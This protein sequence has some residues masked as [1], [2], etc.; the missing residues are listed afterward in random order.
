MTFFRLSFCFL[1]CALSVPLF[2]G[3]S[4]TVIAI[5]PGTVTYIENQAAIQVAQLG[6][7]VTPGSGSLDTGTLT[8]T[9]SSPTTNDFITVEAFAVPDS[10]VSPSIVP[11]RSIAVV[12]TGI[13]YTYGI[14]S[15]SLGVQTI[16]RVTKRIAY[17]TGG[18]GVNPLVMT[19]NGNAEIVRQASLPVL[20]DLISATRFR[21]LGDNPLG[22]RQL[23]FQ[24]T[25]ATG[26][27]SVATGAVA[28][29]VIGPVNDAPIIASVSASGPAG[30]TMSVTGT[31]LDPDNALLTMTVTGAENGTVTVTDRGTSTRTVT[32]LAGGSGSVQ[33]A[34]ADGYV[35]SYLP[36]NS[37]TG[38]DAATLVV[39]DGFLSTT[40]TATF[41]VTSAPAISRTLTTMEAVSV[42]GSLPDTIDGLVA[43]YQIISGP[44]LGAL[45]LSSASG[46]VRPMV[47]TADVSV[48]SAAT[49]GLAIDVIQLSAT[50]T[51]GVIV[52]VT[53]TVEITVSAILVG[54][55]TFIRLPDQEVVAMSDTMTNELVID[56]VFVSSRVDFALMTPVAGATVLQLSGRTGRLYFT[57]SAT[58]VFLI[59]ISV[60][61]PV[62]KKC[63]VRMYVIVVLPAPLSAS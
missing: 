18:D 35:I 9:N 51:S 24:A 20:L 3:E 41:L 39:S 30:Q 6:A 55:P 43:T 29:V 56:S 45:V 60:T 40:T 44:S 52:P 21:V 4:A 62:S 36:A 27:S 42:A 47:Y 32:V 5:T 50:L 16:V 33:I 48:A 17:V 49:D 1:I 26:L 34:V 53:V 14:S 63:D 8:V 22:S 23:T 19:L 12:D 31:V 10:G 54:R 38:A 2:A 58:G 59:P 11:G 13:D 7:V 57:P 37:F 25:S 28:T 61:D 46:G 15:V